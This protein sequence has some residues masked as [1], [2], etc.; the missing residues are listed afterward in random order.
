MK[1]SSNQK[2]WVT[3]IQKSIVNI[4]RIPPY[5]GDQNFLDSVNNSNPS[6][7]VA[8][9]K[10]EE[11]FAGKCNVRLVSQLKIRCA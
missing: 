3:E 6:L 1:V 8:H 5:T 4:L 7:P 10:T 9:K 2:H 11:T